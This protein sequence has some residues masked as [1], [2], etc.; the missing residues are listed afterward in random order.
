MNAI[1]L[2]AFFDELGAMQ[3]EAGIVANLGTKMLHVAKGGARWGAGKTQ[4]S[5]KN[6]GNSI[7]AFSTP[8][9]SVK[10]GWKATT[11][12]FKTLKPWQKLG[13]PVGL[14]LDA[15]EAAPK[16]DP[17]KQ[18]RGRVE[19]VGGAIGSQVG[20]LIGTPFGL[21]GGIAAGLIGKKIGGTVGKVGDHLRGY[22]KPAPVEVNK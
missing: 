4:G 10:R 16:E 21:T 20:G 17:L 13:L 6:L 7:A 19:R 2:Q 14:A 5:I 12:D 15:A 22:K 11:T 3:K 18:G 1:S 8:V 9:D